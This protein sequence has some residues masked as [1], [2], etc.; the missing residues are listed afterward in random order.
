[1]R[2]VISADRLRMR[3]YWLTWV[4]L[5]LMLV[6][7]VLQINGKLSE[8]ETMKAEVE[9]GISAADG[10]L[11]S[12]PQI[13]GNRFLIQILRA[14]LSYPAFIGTVARISTEIGWFFI[15]LFTVIF[16]G[17]DF[18]RRTI[19]V[20]LSRGVS[21]RNY[22][23]GRT[24]SL[25]L[26]TGMV[27]VAIMVLAAACGPLVHHQVSDDPVSLVGWGDGLLWVFRSWLTFLPFIVAVLFWTVL[28]RNMGPALGV[29]IGIHTLEYLYG[30]ALPFFATIFANVESRGGS[31]PWFYSIQIEVFGMTL[32]Y[33]ADLFL[34]WGAPFARDA[35][36]V[37]G[38]LGLRSETLLPITPW[39]GLIFMLGYMIVFLA[40]TLRLFH[41]RDVLCGG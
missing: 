40:L 28:A 11:L 16:G 22:L 35:M 31:V 36:F 30:F 8:L 13:E 4:L 41:R 1:M 38:T 10:S 18:S 6:L 7:L 2:K 37:T 33:N 23:M 14:D 34:N 9:T 19:P 5:T 17:E 15:I 29:G 3:R 21:R 39:R 27:V 25:W 24:L 20:I 12:P 26:A 32:G